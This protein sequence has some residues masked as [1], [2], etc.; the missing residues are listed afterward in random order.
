MTICP[1]LGH[2]TVT[3]LKQKKG[4]ISLHLKPPNMARPNLKLIRAIRNTARKL[5]IE[6]PY[7]WGHMGSCNCGHLAQELTQVSK[8]DIHRFA[9]RGEG[10]W[11]DQ[12]RDY[13]PTS[14]LPMDVLISAMLD[15]GLEIQDLEHL[16]K[17]SDARVLKYLGVS[18]LRYNQREN[19]VQYL[20]GWAAL[21]E[22]VLLAKVPAESIDQLM[23]PVPADEPV[24]S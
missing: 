9:M 1:Q 5:T 8:Q 22:E 15:A 16:E 10:N 14:G 20:I 18:S 21:L 7:Q 19:V 12:S 6:T 11:T 23:K 24:R 2:L 17:L 4:Y 13:C 3:A